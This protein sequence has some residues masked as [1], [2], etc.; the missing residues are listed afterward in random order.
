VEIQR[1]DKETREVPKADGAPSKTEV[2][3]ESAAAAPVPVATAVAATPEPVK[4]EPSNIQKLAEG[5]ARK[6][7]GS[8]VLL[9]P[10][11]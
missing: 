11:R 5:L 1:A 4:A 9:K 3:V 10:V 8:G 7:A 2:A 6:V